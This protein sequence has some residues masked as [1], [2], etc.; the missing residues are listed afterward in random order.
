MNTLVERVRRPPTRR[1]LVDLGV[2]LLVVAVGLAEILVPFSSRAGDGSAAASCIGVL[3]AGCCVTVRRHFPLGALVALFATFA[4]LRLGQ[5]LLGAPYVLF[6]GQFV[7]I[8]IL[9]YS[10]ARNGRGRVPFIGAGI[11]A[12]FLVLG[13]LTIPELQQPGEIVFH[14]G[15]MTILWSFGFGLSRYAAYALSCG[16]AR[17][18]G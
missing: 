8:G 1:D 9:V 7:P 11:T 3:V 18:R 10:V 2:G 16:P 4:L 17:R 5:G 13:D 15:V 14:W 12:L 6:F